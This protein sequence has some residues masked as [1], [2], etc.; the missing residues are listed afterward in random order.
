SAVNGVRIEKASIYLFTDSTGYT[1]TYL[2]NPKKNSASAT[3]TSDNKNALKSII[4]RDVR[5]T[6]DDQKKEKLHDVVI[7]NL[8]LKLDDKDTTSF[9]F[10]VKANMLVHSLAFNLAAG[11]FLKEKNF[12]GNFDLTYNKK[13]NQL[14][15][16]SIDIKL[17]GHPFNLSGWFDLVGPD[18]HFSLKVHT[19]RILY[20]FA[21]S[22]FTKKID[23][24][25]SIVDLD[26]KIDADAIISGPIKGGDPLINANWSVKNTHLTTPFFDF[27]DATIVGFYTNEV[28]PGL[29]RR[30]PNS[31]INISNFSATWHGLPVTAANIEILDLYHP[32]LTCDLQSGFP[33][34]KLNELLGSSFIQLQSGDGSVNLT[35]KGPLVR[36]NNTNSFVNGIVAFKN[37]SILYVPREVELKNASGRLVFTNSNV[38][39]ENLQCDVLNNKI[40]ME[41]EA[42]NLLSLIN[43][44][45]G[46]VNINWNIYSPSLNLN[47]FT[48]LLKS[49]KKSAYKNS[50]K[51]NLE[52][53]A[54]KI[55]QVLE[56]GKLN[57]NLKTPRMVYKKLEATNV[58][59]NL[60][61]LQ[62]RYLI[63]KVN[64]EQAG[65]RMDISGSLVTQRS[66]YHQASVNASLDNVDVS[67]VFTAFNNFGQNGITA[68]N[69]SGKL[70]AKVNATLGLDDDGKA[71]PNSI[72]SIVDFSLKNGALIN[73]EPVKKLQSVIFKSR[74]FENIQFAELKDRL[75]ISNQEI[76]INRMEI[77]SN[78]FTMYVEGVYSMKGNTDMS[79]QVPLSNFKKRGVDY[80]PENTGT[81][82]KVGTSLFI[83]GRPGADGNIQFK[84]DLFNKFKKGKEKQKGN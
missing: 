68:Q 71:Y 14:Q 47:A 17:S 41:G 72:R 2:F 57:V 33:L 18:P 65:G 79:I 10:S 7:N 46:K 37:G 40:I 77:Q 48:Y 26:K 63:N 60:T 4:L 52:E 29:P 16:D 13:L 38:F 32:I 28:V 25:L 54:K 45:P 61:L 78:V 3:K 19:R 75:E 12:Q 34:T 76:K 22:L 50:G 23:T 80:K 44:E 62:D 74:N 81:N 1:N 11:S 73:F 15:F 21:K 35:Y 31:K 49:R 24:A 64:M 20:P 55:D 8:N 66:N 39:I 84:A 9:L 27:E 69:L 59:A 36:N 67:E 51:N 53:I 30:D 5:L 70:N 56:Q 58:M 83:R 82:K 43:T 6:I 42:K